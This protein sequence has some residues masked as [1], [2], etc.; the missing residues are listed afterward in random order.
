MKKASFIV[1][2]NAPDELEEVMGDPCYEAFEALLLLQ[3]IET[4]DKLYVGGLPFITE[5]ALSVKLDLAYQMGINMVKS[6][7]QTGKK[8]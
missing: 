6:I 2:G 3:Q 5:E 1:T 8:V 4:L 7:K